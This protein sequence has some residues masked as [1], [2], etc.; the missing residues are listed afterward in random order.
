MRNCDH[1]D[2]RGSRDFIVLAQTTGM[3][4][5]SKS[6][7]NHPSPRQFLPLMGL[8]FLGN[9][10]ITAQFLLCTEY[11]AFCVVNIGSMNYDG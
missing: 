10:Y 4:Q 7:L 3:I 5:P 6:A 8:D 11:A 2:F 9:V 1:S